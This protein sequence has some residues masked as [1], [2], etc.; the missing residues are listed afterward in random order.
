[1]SIIIIT[2][3]VFSVR[4]ISQIFIISIAEEEKTQ[5]RLGQATV[6]SRYGSSWVNH[7]VLL[8]QRFGIFNKSGPYSETTTDRLPF[9][10]GGVNTGTVPEFK[11]KSQLF[12]N[13]ICLV[14]QYL[15]WNDILLVIDDSSSSDRSGNG[16][17]RQTRSTRALPS[18]DKLQNYIS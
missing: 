13:Q 1:M 11:K 8:F 4:Y 10:N 17:T 16:M 18:Q 5:T 15:L 9:L 2:L 12:H 6:T 3:Y 14:N 7:V